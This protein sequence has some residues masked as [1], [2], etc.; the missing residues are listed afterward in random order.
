MSTHDSSIK[1]PVQ[2]ESS[3]WGIVGRR[4][5][6]IAL[7]LA[8]ATWVIFGRTV[9][10][11]FVRF[12]DPTYILDN[13][14]VL[15]GLSG[16]NARW[17]TGTLYFAN[18][19]PL[20]WIVY[21]MVCGLFGPRAGA[22]HAVN[23][24]LHGL[25]AGML[26]LFLVRATGSRW[27][28]A[29][30]VALFA[31]HPLRVESV[32]WIS[33]TKDCL[34]CC[35]WIGAMLAYQWYVQR[36]RVGRY[37]LV[38]LL[39]AGA[40]ASKAS[41]VTLPCA[42]LLLDYW[43]L[44]REGD[45]RRWGGL[46]LE[47]L[48]LMAM[49][50]GAMSANFVAQRAMHAELLDAMVPWHAR[51][52]NAVVSVVAYL[53]DTAWP[54][55]LCAFYPHPAIVGLPIALPLVAGCAVVMLGITIWCVVLAR[56]CP[57]LIVGWLWFLG[58]LVP[59]IGLVQVGA[60]SRADRY[61]YIPSIGLSLAMAGVVA[62]VGRARWARSRL[63]GRISGGI[64][65]AIAGALVVVTEIQLGT[66]RDTATLFTRANNVTARNYLA[67]SELSEHALDAGDVPLAVSLA[68]QAVEICPR[69]PGPHRALAAALEKQ[70]DDRTAL[71]EWEAAI[72][73]GGDDAATRDRLG[74]LLFRMN[75]TADA[76]TQF[77]VAL[78]YD[79]RDAGAL[80]NLGI[81]AASEGNLD[82]AMAYWRRAISI[83]P[84]FGPAHGWLAMALQQRGDRAGAVA[85]FRAAA[86]AGER[87]HDWLTAQAWL[88]A[89]MPPGQAG[90]VSPQ[91]AIDDAQAAVSTGADALSLDALG[92]ALGRAGEFDQA[93]A[94]AA[95]AVQA[96]RAAGQ[97]VLAKQIQVRMMGYR[98]GRP[99]FA[100]ATEPG[101]GE[102]S[103]R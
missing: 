19:H 80:N 88:E 24:L 92:A 42:L 8:A 7:V 76:R 86:A 36:R 82:R 58:T 89:T 53:R 2:R 83:S 85:Q 23:V 3:N 40:L 63:V 100:G 37:V 10:F 51:L 90:S 9:A 49:A 33:E 57:Y 69:L 73:L 13:A 66:W 41:A 99:Y 15:S 38:M 87:R 45:A 78:R 16:A 50:A 67:R 27:G 12:D 98:A 48:P 96:A 91:Q 94:A 102:R 34:C 26:F 46:V 101:G 52:G 30:G 20:T 55:G 61:T 35:F 29:A 17:A 65:I 60:Q 97:A 21:Q 93:V 22:F 71:G 14:R 18:W 4:D 11:D 84:G 44:A 28:S 75:R 1:L 54:N 32:A 31:W 5:L 77:D 56:R 68:R 64:G 95:R 70:G 59:A 74:S 47:K 25:S 79:A 43:P 6:V 62:Q 72:R 103:G 81:I 39:L